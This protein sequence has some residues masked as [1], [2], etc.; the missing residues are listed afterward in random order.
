MTET[1]K[2]REHS[3]LSDPALLLEDNRSKEAQ[4]HIAGYQKAKQTEGLTEVEGCS[5]ARPHVGTFIPRDDI[6]FRPSIAAAAD[7]SAFKYLIEHPATKQFIVLQHWE[8]GG[9]KVKKQRV[10][11][12][13]HVSEEGI[14]GYVDRIHHPDLYNQAYQEA[15]GLARYTDK[16]I[17]A[18]AI[19]HLTGLIHPFVLFTDQGKTIHASIPLGKLH[20]ISDMDK[21]SIPDLP[22]TLIPESL[23]EILQSN[24]DRVA[25][26]RVH[27]PNLSESQKVQNPD[28]IILTTSLIPTDR[29]YPHT[30]GKP[31]T[32]FGIEM[33]ITK[34]DGIIVGINERAFERDVLAQLEYPIGNAIQAQSEH[35][36]HGFNKTHRI[37]I[38]TPGMDLSRKVGRVIQSK[39]WMKPWLDLP[40]NQIWAV[41]VVSGHTKTADVLR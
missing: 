28:A 41:Q 4:E 2:N 23:L 13:A 34:K 37:I 14:L 30:F 40:Q 10:A 7:K 9:L 20:S 35:G 5:D 32:N 36:G 24:R 29:R 26:L 11:E 21:E 3:P 27:N 25:W 18:G 39:P 6:I 38:E 15:L 19:D 22:D 17:L 12:N 8:C 33:P 31:N 16:P 1:H